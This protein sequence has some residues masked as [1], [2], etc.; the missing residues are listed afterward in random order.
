[1]KLDEAYIRALEVAERICRRV[2]DQHKR[3]LKAIKETGNARKIAYWEGCV[4]T[5]ESDCADQIKLFIEDTKN[6]T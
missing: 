6:E 1:M 2:A 4:M 3:T 5:A